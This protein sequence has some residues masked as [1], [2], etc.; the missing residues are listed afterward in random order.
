M[1]MA[2]PSFEGLPELH[3]GDACLLTEVVVPRNGRDTLCNWIVCHEVVRRASEHVVV[4]VCRTD[5]RPLE[6]SD[7]R[8]LMRQAYTV[9]WD[10]ARVFGKM[11]LQFTVLGHVP[12]HGADP[13]PRAGTCAA[14]VRLWPAN[15]TT[16]ACDA[17]LQGSW[18][19]RRC[20]RCPPW[21]ESSAGTLTASFAVEMGSTQPSVTGG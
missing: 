18:C 7:F 1:H 2:D 5:G 16:D 8:R 11:E 15:H 12:E 13:A 3:S 21:T 9:L 19:S 6:F 10:A 14:A 20:V 17:P 4:H